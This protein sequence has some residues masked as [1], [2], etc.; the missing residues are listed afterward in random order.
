MATETGFDR[1]MALAVEWDKD[2]R[3]WEHDLNLIV[4]RANLLDA[5]HASIRALA[6]ETL[7]ASSR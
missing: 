4:E 5:R 1:V 2:Y 3:Q 7:K 6:V